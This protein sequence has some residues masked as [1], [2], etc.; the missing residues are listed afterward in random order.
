MSSSK[1]AGALLA[2][3]TETGCDRDSEETELVCD[4]SDC[5]PVEVAE[6]AAGLGVSG[7]G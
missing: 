3:T 4:G 1:E 2:V 6:W 5:E 7:G